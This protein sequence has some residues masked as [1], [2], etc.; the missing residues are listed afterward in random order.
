VGRLVA[1]AWELT[2]VGLG[3]VVSGVQAARITAP[4]NISEN[5][6]HKRRVFKIDA[7]WVIYLPI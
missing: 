6:D 7:P 5:N 3:G 1:A 2:A 4:N